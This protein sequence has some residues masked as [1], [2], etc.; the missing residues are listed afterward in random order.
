MPSYITGFK[1]ALD[2]Y[3]AAVYP[4]GPEPIIKHFTFSV[5]I[6][7][8]QSYFFVASKT[9]ISRKSFTFFQ[10]NMGKIVS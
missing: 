6:F 9:R 10:F 7:F 8:V 1:F 5:I 3:I 4:A 2:A